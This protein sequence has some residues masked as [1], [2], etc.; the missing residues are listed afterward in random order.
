[1]NVISISQFKEFKENRKVEE[2]YQGYLETLENTQLETEVN[3]LL[4][5]YQ[6]N[7]FDEL[8]FLKGKVLLKEIGNRA[9][10]DIQGRIRLMSNETFS[11]L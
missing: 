2:I 3:Y 11:K 6:E 7:T 4:D 10:G 5:Q 9:T 1:M 8:F